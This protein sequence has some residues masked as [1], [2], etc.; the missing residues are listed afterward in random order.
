MQ[1]IWIRDNIRLR[2]QPMIT[3]PRDNISSYLQMLVTLLSP[4]KLALNLTR[5][6]IHFATYQF[7][8]VKAM[9]PAAWLKHAANIIITSQ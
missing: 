8:S 4:V 3:D 6:V 9:H 7:I 1:L 5:K 2:P